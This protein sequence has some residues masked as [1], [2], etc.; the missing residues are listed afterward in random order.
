MDGTEKEL[1]KTER[2]ARELA[3]ALSSELMDH[4]TVVQNEVE[5]L[6]VAFPKDDPAREEVAE[7]R[8][9]AL[10][11]MWAVNT[12]LQYSHQHGAQPERRSMAELLTQWSNE[13]AFSVGS[14]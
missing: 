11:C 13:D 6:D 2:R 14:V 10:R 4:L 12:F 5:M 3:E 1:S 9:A 8:R 7:M